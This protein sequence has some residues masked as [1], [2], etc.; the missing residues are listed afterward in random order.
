V[1][2]HLVPLVWWRRGVRGDRLVLAVAHLLTAIGFAALLSRPDPLRD[3][4]L[5]VRFTEGTL[6]GLLVMTAVSLV[7]FGRIGF[8]ELS[9]LPLAGALSLSALLIAFG[10][11]PG[12]S[13]AKVNLGPL[14]PVAPGA[15]PCRL[16]R[17]PL[18]VA[19]IAAQQGHPR[20]PAA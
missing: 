5:F 9:Y 14:Q 20:R 2:F 7:D 16:F 13:A 10:S 8:A 11:G 19:E 12:N 17:P 3:S 15:V 4:M 1:A 18:G 6:A